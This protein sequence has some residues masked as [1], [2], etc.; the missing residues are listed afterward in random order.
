MTKTKILII[1]LSLYSCSFF[2][3]TSYLKQIE[4]GKYVKAEKKLNKALKKEPND[5]VLNY[6][7]SRLL[8]SRNYKSYNTAKSYEYLTKAELLYPNIINDKEIKDLNKIPINASVFLNYIDT[9]C[10]YALEDAIEKNTVESYEN[11]LSYYFRTNPEYKK[12]AIE[13]RDI[14]A[15]QIATTENTVES[16]EKFIFKYPN[17]KQIKEAV[18]KRDALAYALA[19]ETNTI[20]SY[21]EFIK[22]YPDALQVKEA[23]EKIYSIAYE[24]AQKINAIVAYERFIAD[25]PKAKQVKDATDKIHE[26]A[27]EIARIDNSSKAYQLFMSKYPKSKQYPTAKELFLNREFVENTSKDIWESYMTFFNSFDSPYKENAIDSIYKIA[28]EGNANALEFI[29]KN[30]H[31]IANRDELIVSYFDIIKNRG[32]YSEMVNFQNQYKHIINVNMMS[33]VNSILVTLKE[34]EDLKLDLPYNAKDRKKY[35]DFIKRSGGIDLNFVILQ[36]II[37]NDILEKNYHIALQTINSLE[38]LFVKNSKH[39]LSLKNLLQKSY[40]KAIIP[41]PIIDLNTNGNEFSP[42]ISADGK[43]LFFCKSDQN[44]ETKNEQIFLSELNEKKWT[45]PHKIEIGAPNDVNKAPLA[46]SSDGNTIFLFCEGQ[47]YEANKA[48]Y[49]WSNSNLLSG[50]I[51]SEAWEGDLSISSDNNTVIFARGNAMSEKNIDIVFLVDASG[52]MQPCISGIQENIYNFIDGIQMSDGVV[53][54]RAKVVYYRDFQVDGASS[55][56]NNSFTND[57]EELQTQLNHSASGGGDEPESTFESIYKILKETDWNTSKYSSHV[58]INFTDATNKQ[59]ISNSSFKKYGK[60]DGVKITNELKSKGVKL[61]FFGKDDYQYYDLDSECSDLALYEN[62]VS[63]LQNADYSIIMNDLSQKVSLLSSN[64]VLYH[65]DRLPLSDL[66]ICHKDS[67]NNWGKIFKMPS[68]INTPYTERAPFLHP[69]MKTLY[70]SSDGHGGLGKLDVYMTKRLADSCWD[71]WSEPVNLGKEI[72]GPNSDWGYKISTDGKTAYF[73]KNNKLKSKEDIFKITLPPHLRPDV[74][75]SVEG[76]LKD[77]YNKPVSTLIHW[78]DL[79][80]NKII[81]TAKTDPK[82]GT[83]F[84]VLPMGKNYGYFIEDSTYFPL[85][86]SLDLRDS[87]KAVEIKRDVQLVTFTEMIEKGIP[88]AMN[89][90]FF[91]YAK[92]DLL[93]SSIPEL[94]RIAKIINRYNLKVEIAGHTD[95]IGEDRTNQQLSERRAKSVKDFLIQS[96]CN[97]NLLQTVGYGESNPI[98]TNDTETGRA[99]NRRVEIKFIK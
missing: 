41:I 96:G 23:W 14:A 40:D 60:I 94:Q 37:S 62:A 68:V 47:I 79:E 35:I 73:S 27:F 76:Q 25:Y 92:Y 59:W 21:K 4:K 3:Q 85:S 99:K 64:T 71:C 55:F 31:K 29:L 36:R 81:G 57:I 20:T 52:S 74:V 93:P 49:G 17:A 90:L 5:V 10:C 50:N 84:I 44:E 18:S 42:V 72:N 66:Y 11:Y 30:N 65:G 97:N 53:K 45:L 48:E 16:F 9:V 2:G 88:V 95:N 43:S 61:I 69:D 7:M 34:A 1:L 63:E 28:S 70:F 54:W 58:L 80:N 67:S 98:D 38:Y 22:N 19:S 6:V 75:A 82:D 32:N 26:L 77:S 78:E 8:M 86:Q 89:N 83:Y 15:Y 46:N 24:E 56:I 33:E 12:S 87:I 91:S 39:L 13:K 51:N